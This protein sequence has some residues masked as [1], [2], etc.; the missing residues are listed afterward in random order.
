L[1]T[2]SDEEESME[3]DR[4]Q[5]EEEEELPGRKKKKQ[6]LPRTKNSE[7]NWSDAVSNMFGMAVPELEEQP[8]KTL[9]EDC[10]TPYD[11]HKLFVSDEFVNEVVE[12]S[13]SYA[14]KKDRPEVAAKLT[15]NSVR[16]SIGIMHMTGYLTPSNRRMYWETREDT[17]NSLVKSIMSGN[18]FADIIRHTHFTDQVLIQIFSHYPL[19]SVPPWKS[20]PSPSK[21]IEKNTFFR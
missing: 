12:I 1:E 20:A 15:N 16:I 17:G 13:R 3:D 19:A 18:C 5:E 9:P 10:R 11:F 8:M 2:E 4:E 6:Q 7:R 21:F 14:M